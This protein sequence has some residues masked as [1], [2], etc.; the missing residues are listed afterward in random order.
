MSTQSSGPSEPHAPRK[1]ALEW[2][3]FA[4]SLALVVGVVGFL[5][6]R[7]LQQGEAPPRFTIV[8]EA[9]E[10]QG[11]D[12]LLPVRVRN[13]GDVT[14]AQVL[15]EVTSGDETGEMTLQYVP[16]HSERQGVVLFRNRPAA[17]T[18]RVVGYER[19]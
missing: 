11:S 4:L 17:P 16:R 10:P 15:V 5:G 9:V 1:N 19:P 7:A 6:Y 3:V 18:A 14:A 12:F 13:S 2:A 8:F